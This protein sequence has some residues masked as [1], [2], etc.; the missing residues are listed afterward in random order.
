MAIKHPVSG[1]SV[2]DVR[3]ATQRELDRRAKS[4]LA[5]FGPVGEIARGAVMGAHGALAR[6]N[7][8][9]LRLPPVTPDN[10]GRVLTVANGSESATVNMLAAAG[11]RIDADTTA[12]L[13][14]ESFCQLLA[15]SP[16]RWLSSTVLDGSAT[17]SATATPFWEWNGTDTSQFDSIVEGSAVTAS[18]LSTATAGGRTWVEFTASAVGTVGSNALYKCA[19]APISV[20]PPSPDYKITYDMMC[21]DFGGG[22]L[23]QGAAA[24]WTSGTD[25]GNFYFETTN[26]G[27]IWI[28]LVEA[29]RLDASHYRSEADVATYNSTTD[30]QRSEFTVADESLIYTRILGCDH[31]LNDTSGALTAAGQPGILAGITGGVGTKTIKA[32]FSN[33]Q[34]W[35]LS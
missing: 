20:V 26:G 12:S 6:V 7:G 16:G 14:P 15:Y 29:G 1:A 27:N 28:G 32:L 5:T 3:D 17:A 13:G 9:D 8:G 25:S 11:D 4:Y 31:G 19:V 10:I 22:Y 21:S 23:C 24:R 34:C 30:M 2:R 33:I 35:D 18:S